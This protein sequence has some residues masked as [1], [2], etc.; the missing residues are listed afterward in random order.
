MKGSKKV[1]VFVAI[2]MLALALIGCQPAPATPSTA[3]PSVAAPSVAAPSVAAPT[4]APPPATTVNAASAQGTAGN[5]LAGLLNINGKQIYVIYLSNETMST[6]QSVSNVFVKSLVERAGGKCDVFTAD[7]DPVKQAQQYEDAIV[8]KPDIII[9]KP[10]DSAAIVPEVQKVNAAGIPILSIDV[11]PDGGTLLTHIETSQT[12]LGK[13]NADFIGAFYKKLGTRAEVIVINGQTEASNSQERR[14]GFMDEVKVLGNID[15]LQEYK[16]DWDNVK[17]LN[18]TND[19]IIKYPQ[20]NAIQ[21]QSDA[22]LQGITQGLKQNQRL[23]VAGDP[24]HIVICSTDGD[25]TC[26]SMIKQ[27]LIDHD[28]EHNSALHADIA[29]KVIIDYFHGFKIPNP[30]MFSAL[31]VQADNINDPMRWGNLDVK[32]VANWPVMNQDKYVMQT[33]AAK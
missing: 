1:F 13:L 19:A 27:G 3:A 21:C 28:A 24:K 23:F 32:N 26:I 22:M 31:D 15:I 9:T 7:S 10:V 20:C 33:P 8:K 5:P 12:D 4:T 6:W 17:A 30:I 25:A 16:C 29:V 2:A 18:A 11:K 14:Q